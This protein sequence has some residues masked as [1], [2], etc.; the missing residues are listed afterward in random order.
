MK[1]HPNLILNSLNARDALQILEDFGS[2][3]NKTLFIK[4]KMDVLL[5]TITDGDIRRGLLFGREI[6]DNVSFF[7]DVLRCCI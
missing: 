5:G 6:S 3:Q 2:V 7:I 1:N 4:N